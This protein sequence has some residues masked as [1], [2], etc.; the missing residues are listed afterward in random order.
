MRCGQRGPSHAASWSLRHVR[1]GKRALCMGGTMAMGSSRVRARS[2]N[3]MPQEEL[4]AWID[5]TLGVRSVVAAPGV[6]YVC[7]DEIRAQSF[8]A[9]R[10][11]QRPSRV[12][13]LTVR[14]LVYD[15][16]RDAMDELAAF[17]ICRGRLPEAR[18]LRT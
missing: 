2:K 14:E 16:H 7:R 8:F 5:A 6:F 4:R 11:R 17:I 18:E 10:V 12:R 9:S 13:R 15:T 3:F 1:I